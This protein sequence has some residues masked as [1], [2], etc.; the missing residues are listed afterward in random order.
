MTTQTFQ[1][2]ASF[3]RINSFGGGGRAPIGGTYVVDAKGDEIFYDGGQFLPEEFSCKK[4]K[5][6][7]KKEFK[8][9]LQELSTEEYEWYRIINTQMSDDN[10]KVYVE[11]QFKEGYTGWKNIKFHSEEIARDFK[12]FV[13]LMINI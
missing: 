9:L 10:R 4:T 12:I 8:R 13:E 1:T 11:F 2:T 3:Q 7:M 6:R 5:S